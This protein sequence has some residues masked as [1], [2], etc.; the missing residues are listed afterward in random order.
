MPTIALTSRSILSL[1]CPANKGETTYW[2]ADL[3]GF[4]LRVRATGARSWVAQFRTKV[5]SLQK[6]SLGDAGTVKLGDARKAAE[7]LLAAA[8]L[9]GDPAA[10][11][12]QAKASIGTRAMVDAYLEHQAA[13]M[14]A[15]SHQELKRHL[16]VHA[17]PLHSTPAC[18]VTQR[19]VV[20]LLGR[21]AEAAP[22][23]ANR[24]RASL[25][26]M[27]A[28]GMKAG[29]V[30]ANPI[31]IT[32]KPANESPRARVLSAAELATVWHA[33]GGEHDHDRI[34]R[35]LMLTGA[36]REE[37]AGMGWDEITVHPDG[38]AAWVLPAERS[39]NNLPHEMILPPA[40]VLL[41]P[42]E[43]KDAEGRRRPLM[44]G[45][46]AG[47]FSGWSRCKERLDGR[48]GKAREK[49]GD[50]PM[51]AWVLHDLRRTFV[52]TLNDLGVEPHIIEALVNHA[53]GAARAGV[54]GVYNRAAYREQ[55][56]KALE[57]WCGHVLDVVAAEPCGAMS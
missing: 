43:R 51:P 47:P 2:A 36:R 19:E 29:H 25:S 44:F 37:V 30:L 13:R 23:A 20:K 1:P 18:D 3:P 7:R 22:V 24:V 31:A 50:A 33:T 55:K 17:K 9:G 38:T 34:V 12:R 4:G 27:F 48:I 45:E 26:A 6:H 39:K 8:K 21:I 42:P 56:R 53:S 41:L 15:R 16:L 54:A 57:L 32:F 52:T 28:W 10:A 5:G 35:L 49:A 40:V 46:G 11:R 14:K